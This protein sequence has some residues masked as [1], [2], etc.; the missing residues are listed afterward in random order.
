VEQVARETLGWAVYRLRSEY[1][2][3]AG[4]WLR[5]QTDNIVARVVAAFPEERAN[6]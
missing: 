6:G 3:S 1:A 2:D 4:F 5:R